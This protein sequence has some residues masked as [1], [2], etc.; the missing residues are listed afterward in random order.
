[1]SVQKPTHRLKRWLKIVRA[2]GVVIVAVLCLTVGIVIFY[3]EAAAQNIDRLRDII[4]DAP[5]AQLETMV[6]SIQDQVQNVEYQLGLRKPA[7]PWEA[8]DPQSATEQPVPRSTSSEAAIVA[9]V[10]PSNLRIWQLPLLTP[11]GKLAGEGQWSAYLHAVDGQETVAYRTFLE[12]DPHR[13][14]SVIAIV[15]FDLQSTRLHFILGTVE[16]IP[17]K[18]QPSRTGTIPASDLQP[19]TLLATFNG[20]FKARHGHFGAMADSLVALPPINGLATVAMYLDGHVQMGEWGKDIKDSPDLVAWRQNGK[21]LI[22]NGQITPDT[23]QANELWGSTIQGGSIT[24]RSALGLSTDGKTLY[25]AAGQQSD[26]VNL[27]N[28]MARAGAAEA[29]EL[30]VNNFWVNFAAIR[31]NG[32]TLSAEPLIEAMNQE[33]GRYLK[34]SDRD[35]FYVTTTTR[36]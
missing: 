35:F 18:P 30:D 7:A 33:V 22:N 32:S 24:W 21:L 19:G 26:V 15:A 11:F 12:P 23:N 8:P 14:Y 31:W 1:M 5:V 17:A 9:T 34:S 27:A 16:P 13:P 28:A 4:G 36:Q 10:I 2:I 25:Y 20:G 3:P 6:L 29:L